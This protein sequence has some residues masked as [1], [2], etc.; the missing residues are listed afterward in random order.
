MATSILLFAVL[1]VACMF[2]GLAGMLMDSEKFADIMFWLSGGAMI[3]CTALAAI[4]L[5]ILIF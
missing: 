4:G 2:C 3:V 5:I 1:T